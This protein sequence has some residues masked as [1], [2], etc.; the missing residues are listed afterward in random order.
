MRL[1]P[2]PIQSLRRFSFGWVFLLAAGS[3]APAT[4]AAEAS[5]PNIVV[6]VADDLGF[7]DLGCYG[8]TRIKTP[9]GDRLAA[10]GVRFT[11]GYAPSA[12]GTPTRYSV[13]TGDYDTGA[14]WESTPIEVGRP[15]AAPTPIFA[16]LDPSVVA[17]ELARLAGE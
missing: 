7:G 11:E 4:L 16:K 17:D 12:T 10:A 13:L 14:R 3:Q 5:R 1:S 15:I 6:I 8:A 2:F 9:M